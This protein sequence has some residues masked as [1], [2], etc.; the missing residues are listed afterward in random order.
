MLKTSW[1]T[2]GRESHGKNGGKLKVV[3]MHIGERE[4]GRQLVP[5]SLLV[6]FT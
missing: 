4:F 1:K 5:E 2:I 6:F 3:M